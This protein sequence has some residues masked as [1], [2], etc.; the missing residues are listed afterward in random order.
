MPYDPMPEGRALAADHLIDGHSR[1]A[2]LADQLAA[3]AKQDIRVKA[4]DLAQL[5]ASTFSRLEAAEARLAAQATRIAELEHLAASD[6]LTGLANRRGFMAALGR[7]HARTARQPDGLGGCLM[8]VDLD[9]FKSI[10]DSLGH[11]AGDACLR[12]VADR[13]HGE[14][15]PMDVVGRLGGDEFAVLLPAMSA[16]HAR[17][18]TRHIAAAAMRDPV[19]WEDTPIPFSL[20]FGAALFSGED[21][22]EATIG[23]ADEDLYAAK[24]A[25]RRHS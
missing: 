20:S 22:P 2:R 21:D 7:E 15:R 16:A 5:L 10:N 12:A 17:A 24:R 1:G 9:D 23:R 4:A 8:L 25:R 14:V 13:L 11:P 6:P 3:R 19:L 18:R